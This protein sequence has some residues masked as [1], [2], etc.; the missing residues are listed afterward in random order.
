[1]KTNEGKG[2]YPLDFM[3]EQAGLLTYCCELSHANLCVFCGSLGVLSL[4]RLYNLD[5]CSVRM[6]FESEE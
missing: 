3:Y 4:F 2:I 6:I 5:L 1:M